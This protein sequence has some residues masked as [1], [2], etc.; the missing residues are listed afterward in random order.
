MTS[1]AVRLEYQ[2]Y[3][4]DFQNLAHQYG[5]EVGVYLRGEAQVDRDRYGAIKRRDFAAVGDFPKT[6]YALSVERG[7][8]ARRLHQLG[9]REEV[10]C[11]ITTPMLD[12]DSVIDQENMGESFAALDMNRLTVRLDGRD[13]KVAD[14]ALSINVGGLYVAVVLGLKGN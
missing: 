10:D 3:A 12:W 14:K 1:C 11:A 8:N 6:M 13:W 9:I 5:E 7:P 2:G 4:T